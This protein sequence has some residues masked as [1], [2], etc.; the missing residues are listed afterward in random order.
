M[1]SVIGKM[2]LRWWTCMATNYVKSCFLANSTSHMEERIQ[3]INVSKRE[4]SIL[5]GVLFVLSMFMSLATSVRYPRLWCNSCH[6]AM[7]GT[8]GCYGTRLFRVSGVEKSYP[9]RTTI[10]ECSL[11]STNMF[12]WSWV[13]I[14]SN[15]LHFYVSLGSNITKAA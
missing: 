6:V 15:F 2:C 10:A 5:F 8:W 1:V 4:K 13:V 7:C 3:T 11:G 9:T 14:A 12:V